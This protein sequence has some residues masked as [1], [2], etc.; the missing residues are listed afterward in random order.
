MAIAAVVLA[1]L[2]GPIALCVWF[3]A[4][5]IAAPIV[6]LLSLLPEMLALLMGVASLRDTESKP[7]VTGRSM[8]IT[9]VVTALVAG[10][11]SILLTIFGGRLGA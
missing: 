11:V 7:R 10:S 9:A 3:L 6:N 5:V 2:S 1:M 4:V 8:A